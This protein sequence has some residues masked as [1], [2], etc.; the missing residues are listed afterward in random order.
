MNDL[1][2][3]CSTRCQPE[4]C[5]LELYQGTTSRHV[6]ISRDILV[7]R[8]PRSVEHAIRDIADTSFV[9]IAMKARIQKLEHDIALQA[10]KISRL[11]QGNRLFKR[12]LADFEDCF[13]VLGQRMRKREHGSRD[14]SDTEGEGRDDKTKT[15]IKRVRFL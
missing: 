13:N 9:V 11:E 14:T 6:V 7:N 1:I 12:I 5:K 3:M 8:S 2:A 10:G 15:N 4:R